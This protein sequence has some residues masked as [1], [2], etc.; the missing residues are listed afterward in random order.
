MTLRF[1]MVVTYNPEFDVY[2]C[3]GF[4]SESVPG[5]TEGL[6]ELMRTALKLQ[7]KQWKYLHEAK[8]EIQSCGFC[9]HVT[10]AKPV[11]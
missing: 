2:H 5:P 1:E 4:R 3:N 11:K 6:E 10:G 7:C 9:V 8:T